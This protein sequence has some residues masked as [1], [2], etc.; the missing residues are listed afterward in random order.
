MKVKSVSVFLV[1]ITLFLLAGCQTMSSEPEK[2]EYYEVYITCLANSE[3][4]L[5]CVDI[6][7]DTLAGYPDRVSI[8]NRFGNEG[9][10]VINEF[11]DGTHTVHYLLKRP[12]QP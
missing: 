1:I 12:L 3:N 10:E 8:L 9:W 4:V 2:W 6:Y 5:T 11:T 7:A